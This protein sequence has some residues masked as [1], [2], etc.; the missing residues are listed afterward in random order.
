ML[1]TLEKISGQYVEGPNSGGYL[2]L[3]IKKDGT[4]T[5]RGFQDYQAYQDGQVK[6]VDNKLF[7]NITLDGDNVVNITEEWPITFNGDKITAICYHDF[8]NK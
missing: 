6:I 3:T 5:L 4:F 8:R 7:A 1:L 2:E